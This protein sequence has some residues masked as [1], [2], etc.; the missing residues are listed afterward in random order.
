MG[1]RH[2]GVR[3]RLH[4]SG[5]TWDV[6]CARGAA[7]REGF[8]QKPVHACYIVNLELTRFRGRLSA[9]THGVEVDSFKLKG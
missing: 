9:C 2:P 5:S 4:P 7:V 3:A 8:V 1:I 6:R